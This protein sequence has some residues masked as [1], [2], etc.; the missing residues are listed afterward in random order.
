MRRILLSF[1]L[2]IILVPS[3][4][5]GYTMYWPQTLLKA[6]KQVPIRLGSGALES[7]QTLHRAGILPYPQM[8]RL[9]W[10][11]MGRPILQ[12]GLYDFQGRVSQEQVLRRL[13]NGQST[14]LNLVIIPGWSLAMVLHE[15]HSK[16]PYLNLH[17]LPLGEQAGQQLADMGVGANGSAEGWL[18]PDS[19]RY[20]PGTTA[21]SLLQ[22]AYQRMEGNLRH[23]WSQRASGLPLHNPYQALILASI[24]QKEGAPPAQ[25]AHI[26][27]VFLNRLR[28]GMPLQ[29]D[30][31]VIYA[32]GKQYHGHLTSQDMQVSSPF[33]TYLHAGLPPTPISMP[34]M[35]SLQA[36]LHPS[37]SQDL[38]FIAQ[39]N[40]YHYSSTYAQHIQQIKQYLQTTARTAS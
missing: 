10:M 39:G 24:V 18:F 31:T 3:G 25:Q 33:N 40:A 22:R 17:A 13:R 34:G 28:K 5:F 12:A 35:S 29:S 36:V 7:I 19:Y 4:Y 15:L 20:V 32:L 9:A 1:L 38:Y 8:F 27:A 21:L 16:S 14:P 26:A 30:P 23:L 37:D 11:L 6:G 2:V